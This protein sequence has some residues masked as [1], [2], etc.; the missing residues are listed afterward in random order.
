MDL[1]EKIEKD[2]MDL[3]AS[4]NNHIEDGLIKETEITMKIAGLYDKVEELNT[5]IRSLLDLWEQTRG[6][7][8]FFKWLIGIS[9]SIVAVIAFFKGTKV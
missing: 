9:G 6:V 7:L 1:L 8:L 5:S 3:S 2:V 4:L